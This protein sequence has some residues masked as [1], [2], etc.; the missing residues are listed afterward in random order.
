VLEAAH[1]FPEHPHETQI[2]FFESSNLY[3]RSPDSGELPHKSRGLETAVWGTDEAVVL[4]AAHAFPQH[5]HETLHPRVRAPHTH[6][7]GGLV[8][9]AHRPLYHSTLGLRVRDSPPPRASPTRSSAR[10]WKG[11]VLRRNVKR[12]RGGPVFKAHRLVYHSILGLR[13]II[14]G[15]EEA[16]LL[17][18]GRGESSFFLITLKPG[19]D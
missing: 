7:R 8:F 4:E 10:A 6:L 5:P 14:K 1:A 13:V 16:H 18:R 2:V 9:K 12:F 15:T 11:S 3:R 19:C 17:A